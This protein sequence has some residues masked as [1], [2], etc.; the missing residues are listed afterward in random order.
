MR[1]LGDAL[2]DALPETPR[3]VSWLDRVHY[4]RDLWP[5]HHLDMAEGSVGA[6]APAGIV[7]PRT[8]DE[9][10]ATI[11]WAA[12]EGVAIVP[13]G[14]GSGVCGGILPTS[15]SIVIDLKRLNRWSIAPDRQSVS[16]EAGV[17]GI[18]LET[19]LAAAGFTVGHFP[20]S[21]LCSTTGGWIA[22][23]GAGQCSSRYGK[24]EDML[25]SADLVHKAGNTVRLRRRRAG[26]DLLPLIVGSEGIY[27]VVSSAQ[28]RLHP[29]PSARAFGAFRFR[30]MEDAFQA[31]RMLFQ[32]GLRPA[33]CRLYDPFDS[34][35]ARLGAVRGKGRRGST[36]GEGAAHLAKLLT[37]PRLINELID[38]SGTWAFGG[39]MLLLIF[40]GR[41]DEATEDLEAAKQI[42]G[43]AGG[44]WMGAAP[45]ERW[46][47]HRYAVSY[48]Q[49][50]VFMA[51]AFS[52]TMEVAA[53]WSK[54]SSLYHGVREA[55]SQEVFVMAHLSHAYP[56]GCCIY[57]SFVGRGETPT[58]AQAKYDRAWRAA[59]GAA[60]DA[61]GVI[62]HHHGVGRS[63]K[64]GLLRELGFG[65]Q[66]QACLRSV[67]DPSGIFNRGN[68][69]PD[70]PIPPDPIP[71]PV[72][73]PIWDET[74]ELVT[75]SG[76][77]RLADLAIEAR[78]RGMTLP[79]QSTATVSEWL[80]AGM[81][82]APSSWLD[83]ADHVLAGLT[84]RLSSGQTFTI[85]P[86]PRRS[87][88]PDLTSLVVGAADR[89]GTTLEATLRTPRKTTVRPLATSLDDCPAIP[90][91][92]ASLAN[93]IFQ[94]A[95]AETGE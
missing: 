3:S 79:S 39:C 84:V 89:S 16:V 43:V 37:S 92:E 58:L 52:D 90:S 24:I 45:A 8:S 7:W 49:A 87:T 77:A 61:G 64:P 31:K 36:S 68:I 95:A 22:A 85:R 83:P 47:S 66:V 4:G 19:E 18:T 62:A 20:S 75:C 21:I 44:R 12:R 10:A 42:A 40:E 86:S 28:L 41:E 14:A 76:S 46:L 17:L 50:P 69:V 32:S 23:R 59:L 13:F 15:R 38:R 26:I 80:A 54:L 9:L 29:A 57:F 11:A 60:S 6:H 88:G 1:D 93:E 34:L 65:A 55:L 73:L 72:S 27:G 56:D 70:S 5:R 35:I 51:G 63:K 78:R 81:V 48:R 33:V 53:P 71:K 67:F 91:D 94:R 82:D 2:S 25:V 30:S 74:S